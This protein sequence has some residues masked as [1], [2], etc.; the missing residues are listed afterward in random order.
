MHFSF[1]L[2]HSHDF[3]LAWRPFSNESS[4]G[5]AGGGDAEHF[6]H[7]LDPNFKFIFIFELNKKMYYFSISNVLREISKNIGISNVSL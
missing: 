1:L 6:P 3:T 4:G 7:T 2:W 5:V